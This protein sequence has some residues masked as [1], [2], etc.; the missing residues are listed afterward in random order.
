MAELVFNGR[1]AAGEADGLLAAVC[2]FFQAQGFTR[3]V[4]K[5]VPPH[6][7]D[8]LCQA[9]LR[10]VWRRGGRLVRRDLW[11]A[12]DLHRAPIT[13]DRMQSIRKAENRGIEIEENNSAATHAAF[14]A[15]LADRLSERYSTEPAHTLEEMQM[16]RE[17]FPSQISLWIAR[18]QTGNLL[19]GAWIFDLRPAA[20]HTQYLATTQ[21]GRESSAQD[22]LLS[23]MIDRAT[24]G[25]A[26]YFSFGAST[27]GEGT[28]LNS[29]LFNYKASFGAGSVAHDFYEIDLG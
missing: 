5:S 26:R 14:L 17:L 3:L 1:Q 4:Y 13:S 11:N 22:L 15:M 29:G 24:A 27:E 16:L 18:D 10:A 25:G 8:G 28:I 21:A 12:I 19:A 9:D 23:R 6:L 7:H 2:D 20:I